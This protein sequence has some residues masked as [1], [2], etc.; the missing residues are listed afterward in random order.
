MSLAFSQR[1]VACAVAATGASQG[2]KLA[3]DTPAFMPMLALS[4]SIERATFSPGGPES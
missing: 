3:R 4:R 1:R 2:E